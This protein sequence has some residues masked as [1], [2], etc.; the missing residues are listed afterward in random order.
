[1]DSTIKERNTGDSANSVTSKIS[2]R[3]IKKEELDR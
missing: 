3:Y 1:M 2:P